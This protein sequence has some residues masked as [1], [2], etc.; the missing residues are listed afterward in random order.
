[1]IYVT[2]QHQPR[3]VLFGVDQSLVRPMVASVWGDRLMLMAE[4]QGPIR[5]RYTATGGGSAS[6]HTVE[7]GLI[8]LIDFMA[9]K[10]T[11][12]DPR[13]GLD[14]SYSDVVGVLASLTNSRVTRAAFATEQNKLRA[15]IL[16]AAA[17][18]EQVERPEKP[19]D[20]PVLLNQPMALETPGDK[21]SATPK[22]IPIEPPKAKP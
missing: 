5:I 8:S 10:A 18:R 4:A 16:A 19:G 17:G 13:P 12:E 21:P 1:M 2:Q 14:L 9:R 6:E 15:Q 20:E 22:V 3:I 7:G 11:P